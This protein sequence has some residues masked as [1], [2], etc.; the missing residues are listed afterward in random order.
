ML[1]RVIRTICVYRN[2]G[3]VSAGG[4]HLRRTLGAAPGL[5]AARRRGT[6]GTLRFVCGIALFALLS[7]VECG[8]GA[9]S[10][11]ASRPRGALTV[12]ASSPRCP[13]ELSG[14]PPRTNA[15]P[16]CMA[17]RVRAALTARRRRRRRSWCSPTAWSELDPVRRLHTVLGPFRRSFTPHPRKR[18]AHRAGRAIR[19]TRGVTAGS[20]I[21][22]IVEIVSHNCDTLSVRPQRQTT[23]ALISKEPL[24][25]TFSARRSFLK[26][27]MERRHHRG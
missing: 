20:F 14:A 26:R 22:S 6:A 12:M 23:A 15:E 4:Q 27:S 10:R 25:L 11:S 2:G 5:V 21:A 24:S 18:G 17:G 16:I 9:Q 8:C 7:I 13:G 3:Q 19:C 1:Q